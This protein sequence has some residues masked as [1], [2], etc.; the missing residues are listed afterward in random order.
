MAGILCSVISFELALVLWLLSAVALVLW[1]RPNEAERGVLAGHSLGSLLTNLLPFSRGPDELRRADRRRFVG[2]RRRLWLA[3]SGLVLPLLLLLLPHSEQAPHPA[4]PVL[5]AK[6][7]PTATSSPPAV[8]AA[9]I[10]AEVEQLP[11]RPKPTVSERGWITV[12]QE[13]QEALSPE[14]TPTRLYAE[15]RVRPLYA[16]EDLQGVQILGVAP[17]SF[18]DEVGFRDGDV[19]LEVNGELVDDPSASVYLMN[20]LSREYEL[21]LRV[22]GE[23][24]YERILQH[25]SPAGT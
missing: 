3:V 23:D 7:V 13:N 14:R 10:H 15:A 25:L 2:V 22:R 20:S 21:I 5:L 11:E 1:C 18:W 6:R 24:G 9:G 12:T 16:N 19:V 8:G 4:G 17:G